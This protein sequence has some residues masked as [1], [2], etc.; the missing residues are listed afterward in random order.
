MVTEEN[1]TLANRFITRLPATYN[2]CERA[3]LAAVDAD[4][5]TDIG[6]IAI[7]PAT[8]N[9]PN[10]S[11]RVYEETVTLY[12]KQYRAIVVHS[13][14][15]DKRRQK[16]LERELVASL[17]EAKAMTAVLKKKRFFCR[18]DAEE[19]ARELK[20]Q[21]TLYHRLEVEVVECPRYG[22][23]RPKKNGPHTPIAIEYEL[24]AKVTEKEKEIARRRQ[25]SGCFV[26]LTD[27]PAEGDEGYSAEKILRNYK[28]QHGIA[29]GH[30]E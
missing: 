24:S 7:T 1:L 29:A 19:A 10:A 16:R 14:A 13:S 18:P 15:H 8:K 5:W 9:R 2:E 12:D 3:I 11:Y 21:T 28:D 20:A 17:K 6:C 23:G 22:R 27:V 30:G 25:L 4:R 26:L